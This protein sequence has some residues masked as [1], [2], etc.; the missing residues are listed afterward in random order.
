MSVPV[1]I[2][3]AIPIDNW[4]DDNS[5]QIVEDQIINAILGK[6]D[7]TTQQ[8]FL[9]TSLNDI[10]NPS[11]LKDIDL[12]VD[13][14]VKAVL[15]EEKILVV[16][17]YDVD[18]ITSTALLIR[19]FKQ[20]NFTNYD[21]FI[22]N[23]F[24]HGYGL[25][26][27]T[28]KV[29][30][31]KEPSLVITVDN[32]ITAKK[33]IECIK[34]SGIDVIVTDHHL[35]QNDFTPQCAILNPKQADCNYPFDDLAGVGVVFLFLI[36]IRARLREMGFWLKMDTGEPNLAEHLDLVAL[37]TI[38]DQVPLLGL[39]RIF[40]KFGLD[41]M[42]R[43]IHEGQSESFYSYLRVFAEKSG[44]KAFNSESIAF[45]L[46][47]LLN[48]TGRMKDAEDGLN[49]LLSDDDQIA[50][51]RYQYLDR[52][53]QKRRK[54]Q[55]VM[56]RKAQQ[57]AEELVKKDLGIMVYNESFHEGLIGVVASRLVDQFFFPSIVMTDGESGI[58]KASCRSKNHNIMQILEDCS[59]FLTQ[60]GG[61]ANAAGCSLNKENLEGFHQKFTKLCLE[62]IPRESQYVVNASIEVKVEMMTFSL[63]DKL[64][65]LEPYGHKNRK[66]IFYVSNVK[67]PIPTTMTGKHLKWVLEPDLELIHWN[68]AIS[69]Q[70]GSCYDLAVTLGEN[71]FRGEKK[72]QLI[73]Q[74]IVVRK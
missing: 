31:S 40:A 71:H 56:T 66:P 10:P 44:T 38:A 20:L 43:S 16:G 18:G 7:S 61:H 9:Q 39:N 22:P 37:G 48:A 46:A 8:F 58:L 45:S 19:L 33:E 57:Q 13:L 52:L 24:Q 42:T 26:D 72:R 6:L 15:A 28:V 68:G 3:P 73:V 65:I 29:I 49:F 4:Y 11:S 25:T 23:R 12:A 47:P 54:K 2:K 53:N 51:S 1:T 35:P 34:N 74:S 67:L 55:Q 5:N 21:S 64:K 30:Q 70:H 62:R 50:I 27:K 69:L 60:F 63:I 14:F 41:R 17:D 59:E 36:A 32:G